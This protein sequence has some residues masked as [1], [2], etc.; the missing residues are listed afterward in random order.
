MKGAHRIA[1][2]LFG[3][4]CLSLLCGCTENPLD[5]S[6]ISSKSRQIH[7]KVR[8]SDESSSE[9]VYVWLEGFNIGTFTDQ[10]GQF[11]VT[12]PPPETH[13]TPTGVN[14]VFNL[15]FYVANY[16]LSSAEVVVQN[17]EYLPSWGDID[18]NGEINGV[19]SLRKLLRISTVVDPDTVTTS[20]EGP[21]D[22]QVSLQAT[23][24]SVTVV[25]PKIIEGSSGAILLKRLESGDVFVDIPDM[26]DSTQT[27]ERIGPEI[28]NWNMVFNAGTGV[29]PEGQYEI[30][31][32]F[33]IEQDSMPAGL[34]TSLSMNVKELGPDY[35]KIPFKREGGLFVVTG[36]D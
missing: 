35:L 36:V 20:F 27:I 18:A 25:F 17:G 11:Q 26:S 4:V 3:G 22:V 34:L 1:I 15:Y 8:L 5:K 23:F 6:T 31:P 16:R 9:G 28:R 30:I 33:F 2:I 10:T 14:G 19:I 32:Y 12:L 13:G 7:G 29:L 21:I 24:D